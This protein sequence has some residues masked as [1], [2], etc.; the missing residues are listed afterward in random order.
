MKARLAVVMAVDVTTVRHRDDNRTISLTPRNAS[1]KSSVASDCCAGGGLGS[2]MCAG[3]GLVWMFDKRARPNRGHTH[4]R[5][6]GRDDGREWNE[7]NDGPTEQRSRPGK[8]NHGRA[9]RDDDRKQD[10]T[11]LRALMMPCRSS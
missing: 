1:E 4:A 11:E 10:N 7:H 8:T 6:T 3:G 5:T 9:Q 2:G